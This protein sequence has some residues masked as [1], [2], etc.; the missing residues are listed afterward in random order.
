MKIEVTKMRLQSNSKTRLLAV[1][2]VL[3]ND[4]LVIHDIKIIK[5]GCEYI[6]T[7]PYQV[8]NKGVYRTTTY[9]I[10]ENLRLEFQREILNAFFK[11]KERER[12][13]K[14]ENNSNY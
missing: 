10:N 2:S 14:D 8:D 5:K 12:G 13:T 11:E 6:V 1:A 4:E 7:F 3:C 9:P